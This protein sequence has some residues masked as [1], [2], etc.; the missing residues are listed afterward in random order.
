MG[1][2][3]YHFKEIYI[4]ELSSKYCMLKYS[5]LI[6]GDFNVLH[7]E[8]PTK[9]VIFKIKFETKFRVPTM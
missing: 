1:Q 6:Y 2:L 9:N 4:T 5:Q 7:P 3:T 8:K